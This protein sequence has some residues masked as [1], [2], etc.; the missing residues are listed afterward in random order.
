MNIMQTL[1]ALQSA[2]LAARARTGCQAIGTRACDGKVQI[3]RAEPLKSG[4]FDITP[5]SDWI[6]PQECI[7]QL[8]TL[9]E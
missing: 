1:C 4:D 6:T 9:A 5:L 2:T 7:N 8:N 3:V